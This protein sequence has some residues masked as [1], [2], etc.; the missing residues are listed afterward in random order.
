[1]TLLGSAATYLW[2]DKVGRVA[3]SH[4]K[5]IVCPQL[6]GK[7]KVTNAD[8]F[9]VAGLIYIE[10]VA[11]LQVSVDYLLRQPSKPWIIMPIFQLLSNTVL[12]LWQRK[13]SAS[14]GR[15]APL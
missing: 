3:R 9:W 14:Y 11:R 10:D 6:L 5:P 8:A 7:A 13:S 15:L 1:M 4:K 2:S 12:S